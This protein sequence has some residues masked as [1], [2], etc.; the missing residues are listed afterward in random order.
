[1]PELSDPPSGKSP[2]RRQGPAGIRLPA[3]PSLKRPRNDTA[4][5]QPLLAD[6]PLGGERRLRAPAALVMALRSS[7]RAY[8][9]QA[10]DHSSNPPLQR[11]AWVAPSVSLLRL[12]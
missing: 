2:I 6:D 8:R 11:L 3:T 1:M 4:H 7:R 5:A 12:A 10:A 9:D